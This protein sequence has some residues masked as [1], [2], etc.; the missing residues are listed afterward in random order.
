MS[1]FLNE[2]AS[3]SA[4][5][6]IIGSW[7]IAVHDVDKQVS[8]QARRAWKLAIVIAP[9][10]STS[11]AAYVLEEQALDD[12]AAFAG[13]CLFDPQK[14]YLDLNPLLKAQNAESSRNGQNVQVAD[15]D[16]TFRSK[17]EEEESEDD[18]KSRIRVSAIGILRW[19]L[20]KYSYCTPSMHILNLSLE[21]RMSTLPPGLLELFKAPLL[22]T[23]LFYDSSASFFPTSLPLGFGQPSV[24]KQL[25]WRYK[26]LS[27]TGK[28]CIII[29]YNIS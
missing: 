4:A 15:D 29:L 20:G 18:R 2:T 13:Q 12:L 6:D 17:L 16:T 11:E 22:W 27:G 14:L 7:C 23:V 9:E 26:Y 5:H 1:H 10:G 28:V 21:L 25:V 19:F 8:I 3:S 24:R